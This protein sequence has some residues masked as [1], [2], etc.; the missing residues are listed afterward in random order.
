MP[1]KPLFGVLLAAT[2]LAPVLAQTAPPPGPEGSAQEVARGYA[3]PPMPNQAA[4]NAGGQ[5]GTA[6][7]N[8]QVAAADAAAQSSN[9]AAADAM[10]AEAQAQYQAD[11]EAYMAALVQHDRAVNRSDARYVRQQR[12]Y[13]DAMYAWR[14]QVYACKHGHQ[15]ACD[16]PPPDP[17]RF[18]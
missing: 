14:R 12:A 3:N 16:M 7:L 10:S 15:R 2:A 4:I 5:A 11:R 18:Y 6:S 8:N 1:L 13:A 17:S 9:Q